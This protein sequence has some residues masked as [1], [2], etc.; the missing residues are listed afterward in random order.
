MTHVPG[1]YPPA[2]KNRRAGLIGCGIVQLLFGLLFLGM[3]AVM[4]LAMVMGQRAGQ[5]SMPTGMLVYVTVFYVGLAAL[6]ATLG[7]GSMM[8]RRWSRPLILIVS[9]GWLI[10]GAVASAMMFVIA[11]LMFDA[12][13]PEQGGAKVF[14]IG[15]MAVT[16]GLFGVL[17]PVTF[18]L[19]YRSRD[20][21]A[22]VDNLDPV[23]R[24]TDRVPLPLL[25]FAVWMFFGAAS[26]A[27][28]SFMYK[29]LPIG[30]MMLRGWP[31]LALVWF[32]VAL[33]AWIGWGTLRRVRAAW[34]AAI[35]LLLMGVAY[36]VLFSMH[37]DYT[38][39]YQAMELPPDPRQMEMMQAM[40][41]SPFFYVWMGVI[42]AGYLGFLLYIRRY[43]F[44]ASSE[45]GPENA[46]VD[47]Q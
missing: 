44:S 4:V 11:P 29:A 35:A 45:R 24:W 23:P 6:F 3:C 14:A 19:F 17:V 1:L 31:A 36:G 41:S 42:W 10:C 47:L 12:L 33:M 34:W 22:T 15:C 27:A 16:F 25:A 43:F 32:F 26:V 37:G 21:K 20:V 5:P 13:P 7:I 9:W 2:Y 40:Y 39:F 8:A 28:S 30:S 38:I 18:V 46:A